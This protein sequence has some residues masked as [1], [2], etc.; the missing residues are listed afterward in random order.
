M[1]E[2]LHNAIRATSGEDIEIMADITT[3]TGEPITE[4]CHLMLYDKDKEALVVTIDGEY[5]EGTEWLFNI[6]AEITKGLYGRYWYCVCHHE[7]KLC[8]KE[9][10][11]LV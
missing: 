8:F 7:D 9:P 2:Y 4:G 5:L 10:V 6:P 11:Y 1:I 3:K